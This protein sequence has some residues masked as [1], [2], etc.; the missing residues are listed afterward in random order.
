MWNTKGTFTIRAKAKDVLNVE[1]D[2][3][4]FQVKMPNSL[5]YEHSTLLAFLEQFFTRHPNA[6]P[7]LQQLLGL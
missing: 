7:A 4:T 5:V 6:F 1:S 2:W 3:S